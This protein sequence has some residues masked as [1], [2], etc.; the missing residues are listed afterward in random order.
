MGKSTPKQIEIAERETRILDI[1]RMMIVQ[2]GYHGLNMDRIAEAM[3]CSKGT[4]Y[5]HFSNKEEIIIALAIATMNKRT[6]MFK[7]A[8][9][10]R[11]CPRVRMQ[12][13]GVA[14][15]VFVRTYP[16]H[17]L[18]EH[19]IRTP[20]IWEKTSEKR[21]SSLLMYETRCM[22]TVTSIVRDAVSAED[23]QLPEGVEPEEIV[24]GLWSLTF[25]AYA[26]ILSGEHLPDLGVENP[27]ISVRKV[28]RS[29]LDGFQWRP[30]THEMDYDE[31]FT[32]VENEVFANEL[33]ISDRK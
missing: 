25:G 10:F 14:A 3:N 33:Q 13:I 9:I 22:D 30:L 11:G 31:V 1:A 17:M 15:E 12:A 23:L 20:S 16:D 19:L 26:I 28:C 8:A 18:V 32:Q 27:Y 24:F 29:I 21:R 5:N 4:V 7:R 2:N 6:E